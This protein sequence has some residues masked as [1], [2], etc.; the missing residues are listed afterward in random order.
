MPKYLKPSAKPKVAKAKQILPK[1]FIK[2]VDNNT[3][4]TQ[5]LHELIDKLKTANVK[6][7]I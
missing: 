7:C 6:F 4:A 3:E 5:M 1:S 2:A